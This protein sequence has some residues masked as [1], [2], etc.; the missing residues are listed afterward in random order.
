M[1]G[2][3]TTAA[4][5]DYLGVKIQTV[6]A[7]VSRGV[8]APVR[9]EAGTGSLFRL[10][11][12]QSL[13]GSGRSGRRRRPTVSDDVRTTITEVS[14]GGLAYRGHDVLDLA[15]T[16]SFE[17]VRVLLTG[18][19]GSDGVPTAEEQDALRGLVGALP[20]GTAPLD[21]FK[22]AVL[23]G[24][25]TDVGRHDRSPS[26]VAHAGRRSA[27][28]MALTLPGARIAP[29][30]APTLAATLATAL[31]PCPA[32]LLDAVLVVLA[33]H[34]LAV[35][36]TA[37]RVAVSSGA[38]AY[39]ALLAGLAAADSPQ[40]M[41]APVRAVDWL[42]R[43]VHAPQETLDVALAGEQPPPGF[44]HLVYTDQDPRAQLLLDRL[45][46]DVPPQELAAL[47]LVEEE[48]LVR[49]GWVLNVDLALALLVRAHRVPRHA[50]P[51]LFAC[52][53]TAGWA[54]HAIE[55]LQEPGMRFRLRGVYSG[56]RHAGQG[57]ID[58]G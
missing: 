48:L 53:R 15:E 36:T 44:G 17:Q 26:A 27:W 19:A 22:H 6:Y 57:E 21:R 28:L 47:R 40:H 54:A 31:Q 30:A 9:R 35:S 10:E 43:A 16:A 46:E 58:R 50:G 45:G 55:E 23:V 34:D 20:V 29:E 5:A 39:S 38:D 49:R 32:G 8:L 56:R 14:A 51:V 13:V 52:A 41:V 3:L 33:D 42:E 4:V 18:Q 37:V 2:E 12:V 7:Y 25:A 24:A 11:D 1:T